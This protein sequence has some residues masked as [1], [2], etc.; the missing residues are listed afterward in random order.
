M[1]KEQL[2]MAGEKAREAFHNSALSTEDRILASKIRIASGILEQFDDP[3]LAVIDCLHYL[4]ELHDMPA[5]QEIF[6]VDNKVGLKSWFKSGFKKDSRAEIVETVTTINL[7][8]AGFISKFT[9]QRMAVLDWP[10]IKCGTRLVHPIH[11]HCHLP[12]L[13]RRMEITLP[14]DILNIDFEEN[15]VLP[16]T[17]ALKKRGNLVCYTRC[18]LGPQV[19]IDKTTGKLQPY[20]RTGVRSQLKPH[21]HTWNPDPRSVIDIAVDKDG[22]AYV[23]SGDEKFGYSLSTY[24]AVSVDHFP[25]QFSIMYRAG[26]SAIA[27][28]KDKRIVICQHVLIG[29]EILKIYLCRTNGTLINSFAFDTSLISMTNYDLQFVSVSYDDKIIIATKTDNLILKNSYVARIFTEDGEL[30]RS[31]KFRQSQGQKY[32]SNISYNKVTKS[33]IV[34]YKIHD[35]F[36]N[37]TFIEYFSDQTGEL[38]RSYVLYETNNSKELQT[39]NLVCHPNGALALVNHEPFYHRFH[40][41]YFYANH[42]VN[43]PLRDDLLYE[44]RHYDVSDDGL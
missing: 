3:E 25:L 19:K 7:I 16:F 41:L 23:L 18:S 36:N 14:W 20:C 9:K 40:P 12:N 15:E 13:T 32:G 44:R 22:T 10:M 29:S 28:T 24:T 26:Y 34:Y 21:S 33:F 43:S 37:K 1:A 5:I 42:H 38:Q 31:V 6:S 35:D 17:H 11:D 39:F 4:K 30:Q 2:K 8:L 27:V